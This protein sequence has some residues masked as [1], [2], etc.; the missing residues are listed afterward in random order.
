M[1][2]VLVS[3]I[4]TSYNSVDYINNILDSLLEQSFQSFELIVIDDFSTDNSVEFLEHFVADN[5]QLSLTLI[6]NSKNLGQAASINIGIE[7]AKGEYFC[8][9]DSD[10]R[11]AP[12]Y[13]AALTTEIEK[14]F[15]FVYCGFDTI[16]TVTE[17]TTPFTRNRKYL[18]ESKKIISTYLSASNHFAFVGAIY[19][20]SFVNSKKIR[21]NSINRYGCDI[22]FICEL[23]LM[24]PKCSCVPESLYFYLV[25][26]NS[27]STVEDCPHIFHCVQGMER[28]QKKIPSIFK[29][30]QFS[31]TRKASLIYHVITELGQRRL[32]KSVR[33]R[34]KLYYANHFVLYLLLNKRSRINVENLSHLKLF[35]KSPSV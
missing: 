23:F 4:L 8:L 21:F 16:D 14:G 19:R 27:L 2:G 17:S 9:V 24:T 15:D 30:I 11:I 34:T 13:L 5:P 32:Q 7:N 25:R 3:V 31:Y 35:L 33:L 29:R 10:D 28:I 22:E 1:D 18:S 6:K 20:R 26:P 12:N